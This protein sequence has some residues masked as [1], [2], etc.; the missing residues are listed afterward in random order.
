MK[1]LTSYANVNL[2]VNFTIMSVFNDYRN[3]ITQFITDPKFDVDRSVD[4]IETSRKILELIQIIGTSVEPY[5]LA[6]TEESVVF[7]VKGCSQLALQIIPTTGLTSGRL[8]VEWSLQD[9]VLNGVWAN[10]M[11]I[12]YIEFTNNS[13]KSLIVDL[14]QSFAYL[15]LRT[16]NINGSE[17]LEIRSRYV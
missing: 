7:D 4:K 6:N 1:I 12:N 14:K 3:R 8:Y 11:A 5:I 2:Y 13:A 10:A 15:R 9:D 16:S 17:A